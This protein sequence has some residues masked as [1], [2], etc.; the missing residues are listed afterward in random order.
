MLSFML[1][2]LA[3]STL[4]RLFHLDPNALRLFAVIVIGF[5]GLSMIIPALSRM[6][7]AWVSRLTGMFGIQG[8]TQSNG[9]IPGF[10]TGFSL[11]IVWS[12][13]AGPILASIATLAATGKVTGSVV[14]VTLSYIIGI[15]IPLFFFAYGGQKVFSKTKFLSARTCTIQQIFGVVMLLTALAIYTNYDIYL[16]TQLLNAF[17]QFSTALNSFE[18]SSTVTKQLNALKGSTQQSTQNTN[19]LFNTNTP[20][21]DFVGIDKWL[22]LPTGTQE[23]TMKDLKGKVV[24]VDFWTYTCINCIRTLPHVTSWYEK[25]KDEGFVVI[26]VH[27]PEFAFEHETQNVLQAIQTYNIHYPVAQDNE[28]ATWNNYSNQYWPAEYLIDAKGNIRRT[29][30]GEGEYDTT[31]MAIQALLKEAG[32]KVTT[33][34][35]SMPDTT[36]QGQISPETYLGSKRMQFYY[37]T[38]TLGNG[39]Q[40]FSLTDSPPLNSFSYG[41]TW[42]I[43]DETAIAGK[44]AILTYHFQASKVYIILRPGTAGPGAHVKIFLDG[45]AIDPS[46]AGTDV[47]NGT[48]TIDTDR[49]Y[50]LVDLHGKTEEHTIRLEFQTP[51]IEAYTFTFG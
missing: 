40:N 1:F 32:K 15:G 44:N 30:F 38:S 31:E 7:E 19:D 11:G 17:P 39:Q 9:F 4:I 28:Y 5:L 45:K 51:G 6:T 47:S 29:H 37:P 43:T 33:S 41:G 20:A 22:N 18:S 49:L 46:V 26:G 34:L 25:Y 21:P 50:N 27:T 35:Q 23:L 42:N 24:L 3:I 10:I 12:P 48:L 14:L 13:C 16:E 2:T 8:Q 36:P